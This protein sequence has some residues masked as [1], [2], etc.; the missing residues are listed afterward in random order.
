L[1]KIT[2]TRQRRLVASSIA[3]I[4]AAA[5]V[6]PSTTN[7]RGHSGGSGFHG[8][9]LGFRHMHPLTSTPGFAVLHG[10]PPRHVI[11]SRRVAFH[12]SRE[13]R[14]HFFTGGPD[15]FWVDNFAPQQPLLLT[16]EP[17]MTQQPFA[18]RH[19]AVMRTPDPEQQGIIV[20]RG[21]SK[22]YVTFSGPKPG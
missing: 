8:G 12:H 6:T 2:R 17:A 1:A 22:A 16:E 19:L 14:S 10:L 13:I 11:S 9:V 4:M 3:V 20:V 15:S 5:I 21:T 18:P 7:A